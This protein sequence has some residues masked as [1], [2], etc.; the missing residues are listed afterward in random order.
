MSA[1]KFNL[2]PSDTKGVIAELLNEARGYDYVVS[3]PESKYGPR[4]VRHSKV[5]S[6]APCRLF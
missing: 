4:V 1:E 2:P 6:S 5:M 3:D